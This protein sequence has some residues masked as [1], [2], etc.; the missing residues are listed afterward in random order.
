VSTAADRADEG[1]GAR[2]KSAFLDGPYL[3]NVLVSLGVIADTFETACTWDRFDALH[4]AI[5]ANVGDAMRRE[6]GAGSI[7]CRLTHVYPDGP[8]PYYT[9]LAPGRRGAELEQW[10]VIK[11]VA[12]D[13]LLAHGATITHHHAVGR[14]HKPWYERQRPPLFGDALR[15]V[16]AT[17][18]PDGILA[19]GVLL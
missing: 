9:F 10:A 1:G 4:A 18:D 12:S 5:L 15:A 13:T 17:W 11:Q 3:Q 19:P 8:A 14:M 2:W 6:C 7:S 16:K